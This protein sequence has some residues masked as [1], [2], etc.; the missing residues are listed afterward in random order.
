MKDNNRYHTLAYR[1]LIYEFLRLIIG[2]FC[3]LSTFFF[4]CEIGNAL[5]LHDARWQLI[6]I[7]GL[8]SIICYFTCLHFAT[9]RKK[10]GNSLRIIIKS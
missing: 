5:L 6:V 2:L 1:Y 10:I 8:F 3:I 9:L 4:I 7:S